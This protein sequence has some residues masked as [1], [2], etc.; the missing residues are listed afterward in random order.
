MVAARKRS[1]SSLNVSSLFDILTFVHFTSYQFVLRVFDSQSEAHFLLT[2]VPCLPLPRITLS[3]SDI[4]VS[5]TLTFLFLYFTSYQFVL[6]VF[7]SQSFLCFLLTFV[8]CLL[9]PRLTLSLSEIF[10]HTFTFFLCQFH[11][12]FHFL[13]HKTKYAGD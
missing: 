12:R 1:S 3:L 8:P 6:R 10:F 11:S 13:F 5:F 4:F 7:D 2:F 9:L